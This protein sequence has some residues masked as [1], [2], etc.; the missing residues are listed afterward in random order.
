MPTSN[1]DQASSS[2]FLLDQRI[3]RWIWESGWDE[4]KDAQERAIPL[5]MEANKDVIVAAATASGKTEAAFLPI[6]TRLLQQDAPACVVY[7]SPLKAL[8]NDQWGRLAG[9]CERL[10]IPVTPWHGDISS[11][12]KKRFLK[13]PQGCLLIT[14]ES[15]EAFLM[16]RGH[17]LSGLLHGLMYL[18]VDEL[19][20]F[21][22]TE[23]GKQLQSLMHR[24]DISLKRKVP[25]IALS[26]TLGDMNL[27]AD[28]L[29][30]HYGS[31]VIVI[32]SE[33]NHQELKVLIKGYVALP[34]TLTDKEAGNRDGVKFDET[35]PQGELAICEHLYKTLRGTNNLVFTNSRAKVEIYSDLLR[36]YCEREK[37][38]NEF[39]PHHGSLAKEI[40]EETEQALKSLDRPAT[41][42][43]TTTLELGIDIGSVKSVAQIG[44]APSVA[45]L[46]QRLGRS[47]RRNGEPAVLRCYAL[48]AE[49]TSESG[50]SDQLREGLI[51]SI[52]QIRLLVDGWYESPQ[53]GGIHL[54]T[55]IQQLLSLIAQYGGITASDAWQILCGTGP[56]HAVN[57]QDF[58]ILLQALGSKDVLTQT[59][60]GLLLHGGLGERLV[61]D[62][63]FYAAFTSGEEFRVVCGGKTLGTL[64]LLQP[65]G[66]GSYIIF[67]GRRWQV[68]LLDSER[69]LIQVIP[70]KGGK[71]PIF[72]GSRGLVG[73]RV[74]EE[75]R[76]V[77]AD[78]VPVPFL[79]SAA[80][81]LLDEARAYFNRLNLSTEKVVVMGNS[82]R[83]FLWKGDQVMNTLE[84]MLKNKGLKAI[85]EGLFITV[86]NVTLV[87]LLEA[88]SSLMS[89]TPIAPELLVANVMNK[90]QEKWDVLLPDNLLCRNYASLNLNVPEAYQA[91]QTDFG[92]NYPPLL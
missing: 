86:D 46:R 88:F 76:K 9:L 6:L 72:G 26:A 41:A 24:I 11:T 57:T 60:S 12:Q 48:E 47:G 51:Q 69:K 85:S 84:L 28:F 15:L 37:L 25:R 40:R 1:S 77:L 44:P 54:S 21:I 92:G 81:N 14:P 20:A 68:E 62:Y 90:Y 35:T 45:S 49:I 66:P 89:D 17:A 50:I 78:T 87:G 7:I 53:V 74:R 13:A 61:N 70:G 18:V 59:N 58:M 31:Q 55:L 8:I 65:I 33:E 27:A 82:I 52:A 3:Q 39:W 64:P 80:S 73:D 30:P 91:I 42:V 4:L 34:P 83:L 5:I 10:E 16:T 22:G 36:R 75:M 43:C 56:F 67:A 19:H 63:S 2:F 79:D 32:C 23:R 38:P 29:R 71:V